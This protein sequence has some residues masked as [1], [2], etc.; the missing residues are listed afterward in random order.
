MRLFT[1]VLVWCGSPAALA[2]V[3]GDC[4]FYAPFDGTFDAAWAR[5]SVH[6]AVKG[7]MRFVPGLRGQGILVGGPG[8]EL[9]FETRGNLSLEAGSVSV[10]L[11]PETWSDSDAAMRHFFGANESAPATRADGG[12][13]VSLYRF[14]AQSTYFLVWDSRG[15]PTLVAADPKQ[16]P[17]VFHQGQ[18]VHLCGTW[19]G[20]EIRLFVNGKLQG[21]ARVATPRILR[22]LS[23]RFT[24]GGANRAG[25]A[26][27]VLDEF[28]LFNRALTAA[29]ADALYH[30]RLT[31]APDAQEL[32]AV[33]LPSAGKVRV[34]VN[35]VGHRPD[36]AG[37]LSARVV[38]CR[39]GEDQVLDQATIAR[40]KTPHEVAEFSTEGIPP[41]EYRVISRLVENGRPAA[42]TE[43]PLVLR[44]PPAWLGARAGPDPAAVP[45]PWTAVEAAGEGPALT[46]SCWGPRR[47]V[48]GEA[49]FPTGLATPSMEILAAP[50]SLDGTV[51][52]APLALDAARTTW[53]RRTP[54][55]AE[56]VSTAATGGI[57][58]S[59]AQF[60]EYDGLLWIRLRLSG[61]APLR[62]SRLALEIPLKKQAA[63]L[64][65][66]GFS[67]DDAGAVRR[68]S[69][70]VLANAQIWL[71]NE[72]G[73][74]QW[75]IPSARNWRNAERDR[76]VEILPRPDRVVLRLNLVDKESV[77]DGP[78][79]YEF[80]VQLTP[81]RPHPRGWRLW[82]I[83]P[84]QDTRGTR[85]IPFYTEG[86]AVGTSYPVPLPGWEKTF[87]DQ[88]RSGNVATLYLQPFS[89]WPGMPD[90]AD[91]AAEWRTRLSAAPPAPDPQAPATSFMGVCP[92]AHSWGDYFVNTFCDLYQGRYKELGWGAVY[93]DNASTPACDNA[94]HGCG[95]RDEYGVWQPEQR[96]LEHRQ[97]QRRFY[98][99]MRGRWPGKL[100][101]NHESGQL[102]MTQLSHC[103]G[104]IDGE[105]LTLALPGLGFNYHQ[106]LTL[107]R[108]RAEYMGHNFG[109]VPIFLPEFTRASA[110]NAAVT[111]RFMTTPEPPEVLHLLGLLFLHDILPWDAY[112]HPGAYFHLWAVQDAF[113]WGDD[114]Q[115]LPY[116]KNRRLVALAPADP[117]VVCTLYRRPGKLLA[118]VMN[119]TDTDRDVL[120][121]LNLKRLGLPATTAYAQDAWRA[122]GYQ[123][124]HYQINSKGM[125]VPT[126]QPLSVTGAEERIPLAAG[127]LTIRVDKRNF[128]IVSLGEP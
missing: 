79:D 122:A 18:W 119:N 67:P 98:L 37:G 96:Y 116:W 103:D 84:S 15:Y 89:V 126:P 113:G 3:P 69:H 58:V 88:T 74:V 38:L 120:V 91:F 106:L 23:P 66:T 49:L 80:G 85:F 14:F 121:A 77:F 114:V 34:D 16:F 33:R 127:R 97:V 41:G 64:M 65:Q 102:D 99:A 104:M 27:T 68:F 108:M 4:T 29:E 55:R 82:R 13:F 36:E 63:T 19:N 28:R 118:V 24:V 115:W 86:W 59:A 75:T 100:L 25:A 44:A 54:A 39:K 40:F 11:K 107:D 73:G 9:S 56:L 125:A 112:S 53:K 87:T 72:D 93:F 124:P 1:M 31:A 8:T 21:A 57:R 101:F 52:G 78:L 50:I 123:S 109:F 105:H 32:T 70:R 35:A 76:Q 42:V 83:T 22:S 48:V 61:E 26:D 2:L 71:G 6:A 128:R 12:T 117:N 20:D 30:H 90:Y 110:G 111:G 5:G 60:L 81:V 51:N 43:A 45:R 17:D 95:Y 10:W 46:L 62:V 7:Q 47:Y 92:R 94:D